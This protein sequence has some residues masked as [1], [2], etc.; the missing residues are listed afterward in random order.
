[1]S[2]D[3]GDNSVLANTSCPFCGSLAHVH[4]AS[5]CLDRWVHRTFLGRALGEHQQ[6]P[7]YSATPRQQCLEEVIQA[8]RWPETFAVM[9][10]S[11]G[12]TV[13]RLAGCLMQVSEPYIDYD[14]VAAADN[15]PLAVCRA[16]VCAPPGNVP[17]AIK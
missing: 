2:Q 6:A 12:C 5:P 8:P 11:L 14:I 13:G 1:M 7:P 10:T 17:L 9:Q 3:E 16:A 4:A 15:L